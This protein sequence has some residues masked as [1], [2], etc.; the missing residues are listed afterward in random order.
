MLPF[1]QKNQANTQEASVSVRQPDHELDP[2]EVAMR[3]LFEAKDNK[4]R[5]IAFKAAF[6]LLESQPHQE[7]EHK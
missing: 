7:V 5:A 4:S 2:L 6:E 3:E 1:L